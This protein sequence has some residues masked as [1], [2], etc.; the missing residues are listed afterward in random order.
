MI[1]RNGYL[2]SNGDLHRIDDFNYDQD[3]DRGPVNALALAYAGFPLVYPDIVGGLFAKKVSGETPFSTARTP[4]MQR[5][6]MREAQW[7]ALC[8]GMAMGEPPW[9]FS[10]R[11]SE[12]M[13]QAAQLHD[14][15]SPYIYSNAVR[16]A[17]DGY[18]WTMAPLPIA[19]PED[20]NVYGR[21]NALQHGY[22]WMIGDALLATPLYGSDYATAMTRDI[23]LPRGEWMDFDTGKRYRGAQMLRKFS[24]PPGKT[25][26]FVGGSGVTLEN[27]NGKILICIYPV[28]ERASVDLTLPHGD[29][30]A[31]VD[32]RGLPSGKPWRGVVV[33]DG[34]G[35]VVK[36]DRSG[37]SFVFAPREGERYSVRAL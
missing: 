12:V 3:Q 26:L 21:E 4:Q 20:P 7:A 2:S 29:R 35:K 27:R 15:L 14:R 1:E 23:Y 22:E 8:P 28:T 33:Q 25:P 16:F 11:T 10:I 24:L 37:L 30:V 17:Q 5:Y 34:A 19:F 6:I 9:T 32:V 31:H 36:A 18:P 13:L